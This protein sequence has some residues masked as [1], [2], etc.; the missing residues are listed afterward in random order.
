[1]SLVCKKKWNCGREKIEL[2]EKYY[3]TDDRAE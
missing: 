2:E 1:M 3:G